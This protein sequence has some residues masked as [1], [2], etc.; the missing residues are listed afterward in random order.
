MA[1]PGSKVRSSL[2]NENQVQEEPQF[3]VSV[4]DFAEKFRSKKEAWQFVAM[5]CDG[6]VPEYEQCTTYFLADLANGVKHSTSIIFPSLIS[7]SIVVFFND[8]V[9]IIRIPQWEQLS[10]EDIWAWAKQQKDWQKYFPIKHE[11]KMLDKTWICNILNMAYGKSFREWVDSNKKQ[12][13]EKHV[14]QNVGYIGMGQR[15]YN[16]FQKS[17]AVSSKCN[18]IVIQY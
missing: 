7:Y 2:A 9:K 4:N 13:Y 5:E 18:H 11:L 3:K 17:A 14:D 6:Y 12:R 10:V 1:K 15:V 8:E 16:A